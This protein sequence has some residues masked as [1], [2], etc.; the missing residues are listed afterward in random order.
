M[1]YWCGKQHVRAV[2]LE[3]E[4]AR[5][6]LG[7]HRRCKRPERLPELDSQIEIALHVRPP[8]VGDYRAR[9]QRPRPVFH[10]ALEP[11]D[12]EALIQLVRH[13]VEQVLV[14]A[15]LEVSTEVLECALGFIVREGR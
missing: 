10:S 13:L 6:M 14:R 4:P 7:Q 8:C 5:C 1:T 12:R 2:V 3:L 9:S 11:T 15:Q